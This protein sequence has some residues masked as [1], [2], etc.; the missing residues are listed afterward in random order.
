M[1]VAGTFGG[2]LAQGEK[3]LSIVWR[4]WD[5]TDSYIQSKGS[6]E[7]AEKEFG[8]IGGWE[9][10]LT[11]FVEY[12]ALVG[13]DPLPTWD[14]VLA[15]SNSLDAL[16]SEQSPDFEKLDQLSGRAVLAVMLMQ[17]FDANSGDDGAGKET[18][19][20]VST[21]EARDKWMYEQKVSGKT[22]GQ[23]L[24]AL[25][26]EHSEWDQCTTE[27]AVG[28]AIDRYCGRKNITLLRRKR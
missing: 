17:S 12:L 21:N 23:I 26:R 4:M 24:A 27:Q 2:L 15:I 7:L 16:E 28:R 5:A 22:S 19:I 9:S 1:Q 13:I 3:P 10:C 25:K 20:V 6:T 18:T 14:F 11:G 8:S